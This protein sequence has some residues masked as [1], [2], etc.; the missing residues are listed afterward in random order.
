M[1]RCLWLLLL[2]S[3]PLLS[4]CNCPHTALTQTTVEAT[5]DGEGYVLHRC[6]DCD[7]EFRTDLVAPTG[8]T[9]EEKVIAPTCNEEGYTTYA[10]ECGYEY[11]ADAV[12]PKGHS[13]L[14]TAI[15][16]TCTGSGHVSYRCEACDFSYTGSF[17]PATGHDFD[18][19]VTHATSS[20]VGSTTYSCSCGYTYVGDY[21]FPSDVFMGAYVETS[22]ILA[23]GMDVSKWNGSVDWQKIKESGIDFVIIK[24]GSTLDKDPLFEE[25]YAGARA[26]GLD[27]GAY[28]YTYATTTEEIRADARAFMSMVEGK[29]FEYPLYL[30]IEEPDLA[31]LGRK[32][33]TD[34]CVL[35]LDTLQKN[36][37]FSALYTNRD[38]L[39]DVLDTTRILSQYDVWLARWRLDSLPAWGDAFEHPRTGVWQYTDQ[40][41]FEGH[42]AKFDL[43]VSFKDYPAL[44]R[45]WGYNGLSPE[46]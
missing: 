30:D 27:I 32:H 4:S 21:V 28:Y 24:A 1:K 36:G 29:T 26:A 45:E 25:H 12:P 18:K 20:R 14:T 46:E 10:C 42:T 44:I 34:M 2:F 13:F 31:T 35:F 5:C 16:P 6:E 23:Y 3:L 41:S 9:L 17:A 11:T 8:H 43:N 37:Y 15:S 39:F 19:T 7:F 38:W 40:G 33:L 22:E